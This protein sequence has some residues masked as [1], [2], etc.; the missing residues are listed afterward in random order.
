MC[1]QQQFF[2]SDTRKHINVN[3]YG[4]VKNCVT[5]VCFIEMSNSFVISGLLIVQSFGNVSSN[6][7]V[8]SDLICL[9]ED[10][11]MKILTSVKTLPKTMETR[12]DQRVT[13]T[14][15]ISAV[16]KVYNN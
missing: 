11:F 15:T 4:V 13:I 12:L 2:I 8:T 7:V 3:S 6:G 10:P 16:Y 14:A 9:F 1:F 5:R